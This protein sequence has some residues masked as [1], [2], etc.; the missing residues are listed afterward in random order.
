VVPFASLGRR[1]PLAMLDEGLSLFV[2]ASVSLAVARRSMSSVAAAEGV[3][4]AVSRGGPPKLLRDDQTS[5]ACEL[6]RH[7]TGK[8]PASRGPGVLLSSP[9]EESMGASGGDASWPGGEWAPAAACSYL[10][11]SLSRALR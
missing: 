11:S 9:G 10:S 5:R 4:P 6:G 1:T 2:P 8:Q 7:E 3:V